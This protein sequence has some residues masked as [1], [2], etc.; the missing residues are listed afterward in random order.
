MD[1]LNNILLS[2]MPFCIATDFFM[3]KEKILI[4]PGLKGKGMP[5]G[6]PCC[7]NYCG[8]QD[9]WGKMESRPLSLCKGLGG[10]GVKKIQDIRRLLFCV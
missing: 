3:Y 2:K 6:L 4:P 9:W 1:N 5:P 10:D 7:F 8:L